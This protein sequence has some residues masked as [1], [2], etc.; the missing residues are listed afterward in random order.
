MQLVWLGCVLALLGLL[1]VTLTRLFSEKIATVGFAPALAVIIAMASLCLSGA[2]EASDSTAGMIQ[3]IKLAAKPGEKMVF[4]INNH[5]SVDFYAPQL[6]L[7]DEKSELV[8]PMTPE[9][10]APLLKASPTG[11][12]IL[13]SPQ[14]WVSQL[15][16][17]ELEDITSYRTWKVVR[18]KPGR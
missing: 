5:H 18:I 11:S 6:P 1:L 7:R 2:I 16:G 17:F 10:L 9:E 13:A 3:D 14:Q 15:S 4:Y 12:L 8:T